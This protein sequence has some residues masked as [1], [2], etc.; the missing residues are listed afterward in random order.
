MAKQV[1]AA[2]EVLEQRYKKWTL[3]CPKV[4]WKSELSIIV[5]VETVQVNDKK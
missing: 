5:G 1:I 4:N 3:F 2:F